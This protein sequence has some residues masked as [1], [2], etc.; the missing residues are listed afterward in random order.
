LDATK[1]SHPTRYEGGRRENQHP[2]EYGIRKKLAWKSYTLLTSAF[3]KVLCGPPSGRRA[4]PARPDRN[5]NCHSDNRIGWLLPAQYP[6]S[7]EAILSRADS[8]LTNYWQKRADV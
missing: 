4:K 2:F 5:R 6:F 8:Q 3:L 7:L 1:G